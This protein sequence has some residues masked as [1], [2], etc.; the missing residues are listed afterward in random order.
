[1]TTKTHTKEAADEAIIERAF[2]QI[3]ADNPMS[4]ITR[5]D[6]RQWLDLL[7]PLISERLVV[8]SASGDV[9][10]W[11]GGDT[12]ADLL[13]TVNGYLADGYKPEELVIE[14]LTR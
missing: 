9:R 14:G 2:E 6:V 3:G 10:T 11:I 12:V 4:F 8:S 1:M 13:E 5:A 7:R